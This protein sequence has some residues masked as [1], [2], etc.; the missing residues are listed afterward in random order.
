MII[1]Y[2]IWLT[3]WYAP[4]SSLTTDVLNRIRF[5]HCE[6]NGKKA[7]SPRM[8]PEQKCYGISGMFPKS[9]DLNISFFRGGDQTKSIETSW[10]CHYLNGFGVFSWSLILISLSWDQTK[11]LKPTTKGL[12]SDEVNWN[13]LISPPWKCELEIRRKKE[14]IDLIE[15]LA[16][17]L[18]NPGRQRSDDVNWNQLTSGIS[19]YPNQFPVTKI[20]F[21]LPKSIS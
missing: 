16:L 9:A 5:S 1:S 12:R 7:R 10:S 17:D 21:Q 4:L 8:G 13:Q 3:D 14:N 20:N 19:S 11:I 6:A 18:G 2:Y 15:I